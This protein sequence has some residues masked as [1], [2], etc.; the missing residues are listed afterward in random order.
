MKLFLFLFLIFIYGNL[1][2]WDPVTPYKVKIHLKDGSLK[3]GFIEDEAPLDE[4]SKY[5][6]YTLLQQY[7]SYKPEF[8]K[9]SLYNRI[10]SINDDGK[11]GGIAFMKEDG[12]E[13]NAEDVKKIEVLKSDHGNDELKEV[14][15]FSKELISA[16]QQKLVFCDRIG[17]GSAWEYIAFNYNPRIQKQKVDQLLSGYKENVIQKQKASSHSVKISADQIVFMVDYSD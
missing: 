3:I 8:R 16:M 17:T 4:N 6:P 7:L 15:V 14:P 5:D 1:W 2:A 13:I 11:F 9:F 12:I 10:Y